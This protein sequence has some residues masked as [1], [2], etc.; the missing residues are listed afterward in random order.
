MIRTVNST[1][2][3]V[4]QLAQQ[5][6]VDPDEVFEAIEHAVHGTWSRQHDLQGVTRS[7]SIDRATGQITVQF[8][9]D[10]TQEIDL[11]RD[12]H[13]RAVAGAVKNVLAGFVRRARASDQL[14]AWNGREGEVIR[15]Q[16]I[17]SDAKRT[18][19]DV[20]GATGIIPASCRVKGDFHRSGD[21]VAFMLQK[22]DVSRQ[23]EVELVGTRRGTDYVRALIADHVPEISGG[24]VEVTGLARQD[25]EESLVVVASREGDVSATWSVRGPDNVRSR[26]IGKDLPRRERLQVIQH[27]DDAAEMVRRALRPARVKAV[28]CHEGRCTIIGV[29]DR[30]STEQLVRRLTLIGE[31]LD[32]DMHVEQ[33]TSEDSARTRPAATGAQ[34]A[35]DGQCTYMIRGGTKR[36]PN[37]AVEGTD[38]CSLHQGA[39]Q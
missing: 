10:S 13:G 3:Q 24:Q 15:G 18:L 19:V 1:L 21:D 14:A 5:T 37:Q 35:S 34:P 26:S 32:L 12:E 36:C 20:G 9:D 11:T 17:D 28:S 7:V 23:G 33:E 2:Q 8:I 27:H 6:G 22:I 16:V 25:G 4:S 29:D 38:R 39:E 30:L 31:L